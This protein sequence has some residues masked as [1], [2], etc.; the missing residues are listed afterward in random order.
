[1]SFK[2]LITLAIAVAL[3]TTLSAACTPAHPPI[4]DDNTVTVALRADLN[5]CDAAFQTTNMG[6]LD[7]CHTATA[8]FLSFVESVGQN[9]F[10]RGIHIWIFSDTNCQD[11]GRNIQLTNNL[12]CVFA[13]DDVVSNSF[14]ISARAV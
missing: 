6:V 3:Q 2:S 7:E 14:M 8:G 5:C 13:G 1:M 12:G 10:N 4:K 11:D 9:M